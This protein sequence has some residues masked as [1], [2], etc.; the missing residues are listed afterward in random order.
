M[1]TR[2]LAKLHRTRAPRLSRRPTKQ[3]L[4]WYADLD[5]HVSKR[6]V[7][8]RCPECGKEISMPS[9]EFLER[10]S[11]D[12]LRCSDCRG[13]VDERVGEMW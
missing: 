11:S 7:D 8:Y 4:L 9:E 1:D 13:D 6:V 2:Q 5:L 3:V 10:D 12:D